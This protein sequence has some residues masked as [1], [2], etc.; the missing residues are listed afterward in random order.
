[1]PPFLPHSHTAGQPHPA[2]DQLPEGEQCLS[3]ANSYRAEPGHL[4]LDVKVTYLQVLATKL[5]FFFY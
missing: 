4:D 2:E 5:I 1:M 3:S